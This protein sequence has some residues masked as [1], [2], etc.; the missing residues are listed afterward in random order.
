M[1]R[2][3]MLQPK[4]IGGLTYN[5]STGDFR[6]SGYALP[7]DPGRSITLEA[8]PTPAE[9]QHF[10][11]RHQNIFDADPEAA[12]HVH[13]DDSGIHFIH[14][15]HVE[16]DLARALEK[17]RA[18]RLPAVNDIETGASHPTL[19]SV[20]AEDKTA[21]QPESLPATGPRVLPEAPLG[22][23]PATTEQILAHFDERRIGIWTPEQP[24]LARPRRTA[25]HGF[26]DNPRRLLIGATMLVSFCVS[27]ATM[28]WQRKADLAAPMVSAAVITPEPAPEITLPPEPR[29]PPVFL[30]RQEMVMPRATVARL[31]L[32][33]AAAAGEEAP[34]LQPLPVAFHI[35]N[36]RKMRE[37]KVW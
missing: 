3:P 26:H 33:P 15:V 34:P 11:L 25:I 2:S 31:D 10:I 23:K 8:L 30:E 28:L 27:L 35:W 5:P 6:Q 4:N 36:R 18:A 13:S 7:T 22:A 16:S 9:F 12:L 20:P 29:P 1:A 21:A 24:R 17:A 37:Q 14:V 19:A 32:P